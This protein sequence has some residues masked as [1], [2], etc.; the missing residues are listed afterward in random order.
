MN[1]PHVDIVRYKVIFPK[2]IDYDKAPPLTEETNDFIF[3]ITPKVASFKMK[4]HF[5]KEEDAKTITDEFLQTYSLYLGIE[6]SPDEINFSYNGVAIIDR[7]PPKDKNNVTVATE[8]LTCT[9]KVVLGGEVH[10][11][12]AKFMPY[13]KNFILTPDVESM[14]LRYKNYCKK[15]EN[16]LS[17]AYMC[18]TVLE[19]SVGGRQAASSKYSIDISVLRKLGELV[20]TKGD[21]SEARKAPKD[22]INK[23][24]PLTNNERIWIEQVIKRMIIRAGES[25]ASSKQNLPKIILNDFQKI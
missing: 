3:T 9:A 6:C 14:Y 23:F 24:I 5:P 13:P 4:A 7:N 15:R 8:C 11:S 25:A 18:L 17:M 16:L 22:K 2:D 10:L 19:A 20:S 12:R 1:D 21:R